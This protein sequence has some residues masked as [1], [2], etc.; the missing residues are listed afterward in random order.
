MILSLK[1]EIFND[2]FH[3][4]LKEVNALVHNSGCLFGALNEKFNIN[5]KDDFDQKNIL[6]N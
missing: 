6:P 4:L 3:E 1:K 2:N 5:T